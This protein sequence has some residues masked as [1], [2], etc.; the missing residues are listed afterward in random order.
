MTWNQLRVVTMD[1]VKEE[2]VLMNYR[3]RILSNEGERVQ[4][5]NIAIEKSGP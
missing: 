5:V 4:L 2:G 1:G 3:K